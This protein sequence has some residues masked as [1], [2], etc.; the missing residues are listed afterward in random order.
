MATE[1]ATPSYTMVED[2]CSVRNDLAER[3]SQF[4]YERTC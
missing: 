1:D 2:D 4:N 3:I